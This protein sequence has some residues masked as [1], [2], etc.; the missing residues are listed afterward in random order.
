M[1]KPIDTN[2]VYGW[3][4]TQLNSVKEVFDTINFLLKN[5]W[6]SRG[7]S[8]CWG[9]LIPKIDRDP[10]AISERSKLIHIE[11]QS[12]H[13]FQSV[14]MTNATKDEREALKHDVN[15]LMVLQHYG[16]PT[17][18]LDWSQY[19]YVALFFATFVNENVDGELWGFNYNKYV[20]QGSKQWERITDIPIGSP[21]EVRY[22]VA[23]SKEEPK[24]DFFMCIFDYLYHHRINAQKGLFSLTAC[25]GKDHA[26][27]IAELFDNDKN[28]YHR[29]IIKSDL[30]SELVSLLEEKYG[31]SMGSLFPDTAGAA[32]AVKANL[33]RNA[34]KVS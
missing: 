25:F 21:I 11:S 14:A 17:R 13:T 27:S 33:Y 9:K 10:I 7:Q 28:F 4:T 2:N 23:F 29:Y 22:N 6:I 5:R 30:K 8:E 26:R 20:N 16:V 1:N 32:E 15:T 31:I 18:L 12:I 3:D 24:Q 19:P 34:K